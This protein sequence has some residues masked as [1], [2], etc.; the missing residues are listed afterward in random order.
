MYRSRVLPLLALAF[1]VLPSVVGGDEPSPIGADR[2]A[3][4]TKAIHEFFRINTVRIQENALAN[5]KTLEDWQ[6]LR[7]KLRRQMLD[8]LGLWPLPEKTPLQPT[9]TG[10]LEEDA[11]VVEKLHFQSRPGLYVTAN[12]YRPKEIAEG[13]RLPT[14]LYLCGHGR[15][16]ENG[17]SYGNKVHYQHHPAWFARHGYCCLIVDTLQLGE[18]EGVHHG[19]YSKGRW[20]W[21]SRGYTPAG[22]EAWNAVRALDY[23][24]TRTEV[25]MQRIGVTGRSGGGTGTWWL[26][27]VD[28]RPACLVPVAGI[29]DY[30][31][32]VVDGC[33]KGH[34]DCN[35][36]PNR[37]RIDAPMYAALAAPRPLLLSNSDK[38]AIFPLDG[39]MRVHGTLDRIYG[40]YGEQDQLGL[41]I[42]EGP[43]SD[44][45]QLRVPAFKW[46]NRWL[47]KTD[48]PITAVAAPF[49]EKEE[50]RVLPLRDAPADERNTT[51]DET[52]VPKSVSPAV[53]TSQEA[54]AK[55]QETTMTALRAESLS[56]WP[57]EEQPLGV[58]VL[59][60]ETKEGV[61]LTVLE[62]TSEDNLRFPVYL[63]RGAEHDKP[64]LLVATVV[65][66]EGWET[67][68]STFATAFADVDTIGGEGVDKDAKSYE[69]E[70]KMLTAQ[71]W[72][73]AVVPPRG[74]GPNSWTDDERSR[75]QILRRFFVIG[76][77]VDEGRIWDV[78]RA[79]ATLQ[80]RDDLRN[81]RLW[82]QGEGSAA[83]I[84]LFAGL[85]E[86]KVERFDLHRPPSSLR[87][88]PTL[89]NALKVLD[90]PEVTALAFPRKVIL[91]DVEESDWT[92]PTKVS[93]M[94][95]PKEP[96]QFRST[97]P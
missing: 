82:L 47:R 71:P 76:R 74:V 6:E 89:I 88:G 52:F 91:Y 58:K 22:V 49:F 53:P 16:K 17:I 85:F 46:M 35:Y 92:W 10:T 15:V 26:A 21:L 86:P 78:R 97:K 12:F 43:H 79:I 2:R 13:T 40:L 81:A 28:D 96:L 36:F 87:E 7:P 70:R 24:E 32:H 45:Q 65:D 37:F 61:R 19:T 29:V 72:T 9:V 73:F 95:A 94:F 41:L 30:E 5:V 31:S 4:N 59:A 42:T 69:Q 55:W 44:T 51:I 38:D 18:I 1:V 66:D 62:Y 54:L 90:M 27:A 25:D 39:V 63:Y 67:W 14:I 3:A 75:T 57:S 33:I 8:M 34:C 48:E 83:G 77:T 60:D 11:F 50:L 23:L 64:S 93:T 20:W 80:E 84:A 56:G 68:R